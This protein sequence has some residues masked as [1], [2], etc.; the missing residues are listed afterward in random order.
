ML[1]FEA[2]CMELQDIILS[3]VGQTQKDK[4]RLFSLICES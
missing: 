3:E 2:R 4:Y 1:L